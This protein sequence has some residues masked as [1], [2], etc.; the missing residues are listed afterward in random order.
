MLHS[1]LNAGMRLMEV[2]VTRSL[3]RKVRGEPE[4]FAWRDVSGAEVEVEF[5]GGRCSK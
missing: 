4:T 2:V 1:K 5:A 3:G